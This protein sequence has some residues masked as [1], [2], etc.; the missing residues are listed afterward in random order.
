MAGTLQEVSLD[1]S[2][3]CELHFKQGTLA[4]L[5]VVPAGTTL[6]G[7]VSFLNEKGYIKD[8]PEGFL[9]ASM[10]ALRP[11]VLALV[12]DVDCEV[13]GGGDYVLADGDAVS[14]IST[15]HGG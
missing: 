10:A 4:L 14:F 5:N 15:L 9:D 2:G 12:N 13:L 1:F 11:G 7:L 8:R 6:Q 3:G